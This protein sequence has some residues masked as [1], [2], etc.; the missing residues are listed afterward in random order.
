M[1]VSCQPPGNSRAVIKI[2][3]YLLNIIEIIKKGGIGS[4]Y[5][6]KYM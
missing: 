1:D 6:H 2:N 5:L 3:Y 4:D